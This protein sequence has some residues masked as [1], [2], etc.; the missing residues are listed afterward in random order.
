[1]C[2]RPRLHPR[3]CTLLSSGSA[4]LDAR[5]ARR[6]RARACSRAAAALAPDLAAAAEDIAGNPAAAPAPAPARV[7][8]IPAEHTFGDGPQCCRHEYAHAGEVVA[9][10]GSHSTVRLTAEGLLPPR[11]C[12]RIPRAGRA[13]ILLSCRK[14]SSPQQVRAEGKVFS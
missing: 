13:Q 10:T 5:A 7:P 8:A 3:L 6:A 1:M 4:S 11:R 14:V 12:N 9:V 2:R